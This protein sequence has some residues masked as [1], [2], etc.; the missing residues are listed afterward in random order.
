MELLINGND[1]SEVLSAYGVLITDF[2]LNREIKRCRFVQRSKAELCV[3]GNLRSSVFEFEHS[4]FCVFL[5]QCSEISARTERDRV[6][7]SL[8]GRDLITLDW[9]NF[10]FVGDSG[11]KSW[12]LPHSSQEARER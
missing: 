11:N 1:A 7:L 12:M 8:Q 6:V 10:A 2:L 3:D 5:Q 9:F 4:D